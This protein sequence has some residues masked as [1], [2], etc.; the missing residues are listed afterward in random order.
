MNMHSPPSVLDTESVLT[1]L[2]CSYLRVRLIETEIISIG[3][4]LRDGLISPEAAI[5]WTDEIG[6]DE[7]ERRAE[8]RRQEEAG[9]I[10]ASL[11]ATD[12]PAPSPAKPKPYRTP[13]STVQAFWYLVG[14]EDQSRLNAWLAE[15]PK[16]AP[17][18][19]KLL[20]DKQC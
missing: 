2:R 8:L 6:L 18:L 20:K 14:L 1:A 17:F 11:E 9:V 7:L 16:D 5:E 3:V 15:H 10:A 13:E 4:A 12:R 19:L